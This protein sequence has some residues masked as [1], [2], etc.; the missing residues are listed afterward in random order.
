MGKT[1]ADGTTYTDPLTEVTTSVNS[2]GEVTGVTEAG[3][4]TSSLLVANPVTDLA[5]NAA[6]GD[7]PPVED[8]APVDVDGDGQYTGYE[9]FTKADLVAHIEAL[10]KERADEDQLSTAGNKPDLIRRI[11]EAEAT[12]AAPAG[13]GV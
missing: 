4:P 1:S 2:S 6:D 9:L 13:T 11:Q 5:E 7:T 12:A 3:D 8:D 10:N